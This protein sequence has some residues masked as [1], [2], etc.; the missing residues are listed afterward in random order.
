AVGL[1]GNGVD[2]LSGAK[3]WLI[4]PRPGRIHLMKLLEWLARAQTAD[5]PPLADWLPTAALGLGWG[6]T[7][8]LICPTGDEATCRAAHRLLRAGLNPVLVVI[9][10]HGQFGIIRERARQLGV[11]AHL[12]A[13]ETDLKRWA[14]GRPLPLA[15]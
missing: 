5:L 4:P 12:V 6:T 11:A 13:N 2:T 15:A 14:I 8:I 1:G 3:R 7:V 10:P 9:E